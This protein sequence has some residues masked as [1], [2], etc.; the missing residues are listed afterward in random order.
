[1]FET[2]LVTFREGLEA[3][4]MVAV[5]TLYLRKTGREA[6]IAAVRSGL[7][8]S[9]A[10]S[11][12]LGVLLAQIGSMSPLW[13]GILAL[14][15]A[16]TVVWCVGHMRKMGK[17]MGAE[18]SGGLGKASLLDGTKAWWAVF[19]FICFM[20]GREGIETAAM[21]AAL[22][23]N[24]ELRHMTMGG[25]TGVALAGAVAWAW[26]RF[27][28]TVDLSRFFSVTAVFMLA[29]A[30][31]LVFRAFFEFTEIALIPG[32]DNTFWHDAAT[33]FA[34]G[35]Y[36]QWASVLLVLAPTVWLLA[37]HLMDRNTKLQA[38]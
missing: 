30:V 5:A 34:E 35:I 23:G 6:L 3:F 19:G 15:A 12:L 28:R 38:I 17:H 21:L 7:G 36:A 32:I 2:L 20:V 8:V 9:V 29:F 37:A 1:M 11:V 16:A 33:P 14:I 27:G 4:L 13:E 18:I 25:V 26:V 24:S 10:G 31:L 22:A